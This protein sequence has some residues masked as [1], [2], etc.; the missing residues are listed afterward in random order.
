M[1]RLVG[2]NKKS[3]LL[4]SSDV[5]KELLGRTRELAA[6]L[7]ISQTATQSLETEKILKDTLDKSLELLRFNVGYI[8][9][10]PRILKH[11]H[12]FGF[13]SSHCGKNRLRNTKALHLY[14]YSERSDV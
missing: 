1:P 7:A 5:K 8:R 6:L 10:L 3:P 2:V 12:P 9:T 11:R 4:E 13:F 14:R